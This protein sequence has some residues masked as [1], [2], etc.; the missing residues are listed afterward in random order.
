[1]QPDLSPLRRAAVRLAF[2]AVSALFI[3]QVLLLGAGAGEPYPGILMPAFTGSAGYEG[4]VVRMERMQP[5]FVGPAGEHA[6]SP[7]AL[8]AGFPDS[9]HGKLSAFFHPSIDS[10][11]PAEARLR[12]HLPG[13][14]AGR[15]D[16]R[17][18]CAGAELQ[19]WARRR[20]AILLPGTAVERLE[21]RWHRDTFAGDTAPVSREPAGTWVIDLTGARCGR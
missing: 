11:T 8:L 1:V 14:V 19:A 13:L 2:A 6:V 21:L 16:R 10:L 12:R 5:V 7:R 15:A 9:H 18:Q 4:G 3:L 17:P 20:A